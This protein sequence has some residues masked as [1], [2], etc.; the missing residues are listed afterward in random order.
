MAEL[1]AKHSSVTD[2]SYLH[3]ETDTTQREEGNIDQCLNIQCRND[4]TCVSTSGGYSCVC[5]P[6]FQ[7]FHCE[8]GMKLTD[9]IN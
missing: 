2:D 5:S 8:L 9:Y 6:Q 7:G 3:T 1:E 4:G